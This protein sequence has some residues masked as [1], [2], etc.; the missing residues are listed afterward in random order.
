MS[1]VEGQDFSDDIVQSDA[2]STVLMEQIEPL[3]DA[4]AEIYERAFQSFHEARQNLQSL[5][6][7][8]GFGNKD[9]VKAEFQGDNKHFVTKPSTNGV[10]G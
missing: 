3:E 8:G 7:A 6:V 1:V 10:I 9:I 2:I 4:Q 5:L